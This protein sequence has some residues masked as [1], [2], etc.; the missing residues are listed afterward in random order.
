[1]GKI[2]AV[3][4]Q[5]GGVGKSTII[6]NLAAAIAATGKTVILVDAD[7]QPTSTEWMAARMDYPLMCNIAVRQESGEIDKMLESLDYDYVLVD[8]AGHAS[9]EMRSAMLV[10]DILL[11]P[12]KPGQ[13]DLNTL[14]YMANVIN[15]AN[16]INNKL[17]ALAI[18]NMAPTNP[19]MGNINQAREI[20]SEYP[21]I[22]LLD[23]VIYNRDV[24]LSAMAIGL[25]VTEISGK[26]VSEM[27][28]KDEITKLALEVIAWLN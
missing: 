26:S 7:E 1:M 11:V 20:I 28:A 22:M 13:A 18:I 10:C 6:T 19:Q 2:I 24:Y 23:S 3:A 17:K 16:F 5:K 27:K 12:F 9:I 14:S 25:S 8:T 21:E 4:S 15:Q